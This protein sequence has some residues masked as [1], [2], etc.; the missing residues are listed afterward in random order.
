MTAGDFFV[1][2]ERGQCKK[3][4]EIG[5]FIGKKAKKH[6]K[7]IGKITANIAKV[8]GKTYLCRTIINVLCLK[9]RYLKH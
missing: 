7:V 5:N 1:S 6:I 8:A 2:T 9:E 3:S 4:N